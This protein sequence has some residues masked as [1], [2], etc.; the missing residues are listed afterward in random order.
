VKYDRDHPHRATYTC[1]FDSH[2]RIMDSRYHLY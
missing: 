1:H 2:G